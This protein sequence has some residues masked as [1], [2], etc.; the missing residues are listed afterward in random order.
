MR[1][2]IATIFAGLLWLAGGW[3]AADIA[4]PARLDVAEREPGIY[5]ISFSLP[6]VEGR[7]LR[8]EPR[9]PPTCTE[10]TP[11]RDGMSSSG[12][13]S[14]WSVR[15][16]PP[17]LAGEAIVI[18]GL[19]GTQTDLAFTLTMLDGRRY[20]RILRPSRPGFLVPE[21]PSVGALAVEAVAGGVRR[22]LRHLNLWLML[23]VAALTGSSGRRLGWTALMFAVGH[24][25]AQRLG[26]RGWLE[27][28]ALTRDLL[29]WV[30]IAV[31][32][33]RLA[34][35][36]EAWKGWM[37]PLWPAML[38]AGLLVGAAQPEALPP[39]G[40]SNAEQFMALVLFAVGAGAAVLLM[41]AAAYEYRAVLLT[42][43]DGRWRERGI[44]FA[45][46][47]AGAVAVGMV[48]ALIVGKA[49]TA[50]S[51]TRGP[52]ELA[53]L[54]VILGPILVLTER[55]SRAVIAGLAVLTACG[56][57]LGLLS[58]PLPWASL[59]TLGSLMIL[60]GSLALGRCSGPMWLLV[61][62]AVA[63]TAHPWSTALV[64]VENVSRSTAASTG[65]VLV[66]ICV[67]FAS[68]VTARRSGNTEASIAVRITGL[69]VA[70]FS[71]VWRLI[72]YRGWIEGEIA[73]EAAFGNLRLPLL[74]L[75]VLGGAGVLWWRQKSRRPGRSPRASGIAL[76]VAFLLLPYGTV[77]VPNPFY[78]S[79]APR[80]EGARLVMSKVL[81]DT[82]HAF[83]IEDEDELY[84]TLAESVTGD[85]IGDLYLDN[86][87]RMTAGTRQGTKVTIRGVNVLE[88]SKPEKTSVETDGYSYD[89]RW[90]VV[91]RVQHL[92][93]VHHRRNIYNGVL[94]L[95][96]D[97]GRWKISGVELLSED[98]EVVPWD[99]T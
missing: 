16:E 84:D 81:S 21:D 26:G 75:V 74:A 30:T 5:D 23:G 22:T 99:P 3:A 66:A 46:Y 17:S 39:E 36:G 28:P 61:T 57:S 78:A 9:M 6:I 97:E 89:C 98:R 63:A 71:L 55:G 77:L 11:R 80:G 70:V 27:V 95:R 34:G 73:T 32:A 53:L 51:Q 79:S 14:T 13:T 96:A 82:Y 85:L 72:E 29:I 1:A 33:V 92:Q 54:A 10:I 76:V 37:R 50:S 69:S 7:K 58:I 56:L 12:Y 18:E 45:G 41:G 8:A 20:S 49:S 15:C 24:F 19:L 83:N 60:G 38:F 42:I 91:A 64:L 52:F 31:P 65:A 25:A 40:L 43:G 88:I 62:S 90:A 94:T 87:R 35:G 86:R 67:F 68:L 44:R 93:H 48:L 59:L 2:R 4:F 47:V